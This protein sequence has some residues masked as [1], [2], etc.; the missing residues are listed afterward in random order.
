MKIDE[1]SLAVWKDCETCKG[2]GKITAS[3]MYTEADKS[4]RLVV[5]CSSCS[6]FG[7]R[8]VAFIPLLELEGDHRF[9]SK[10]SMDIQ[11]W[12]DKQEEKEN[13]PT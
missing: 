7:K 8:P 12:L 13:E 9:T 2:T 1:L 3:F 6:G 5:N 4:G 10:T 11:R